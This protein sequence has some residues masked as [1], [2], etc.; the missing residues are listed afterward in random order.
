MSY[1]ERKRFLKLCFTIKSRFY[2]VGSSEIWNLNKSSRIVATH[3]PWPNR[4]IY[5]PFL[6][7]FFNWP[8]VYILIKP[9]SCQHLMRLP[10]QKCH[11]RRLLP[12]L[13]VFVIHP[14]RVHVISSGR[15]AKKFLVPTFACWKITL[16]EVGVIDRLIVNINDLKFTCCVKNSTHENI[17]I[18]V[19]LG[20]IFSHEY[21]HFD[22]E[23]LVRVG[24]GSIYCYRF[25]FKRNPSWIILFRLIWITNRN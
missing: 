25:L 17:I 23:A 9:L 18:S 14:I 5:G 3:R 24:N 13:R 2:R 1:F 11:D 21:P 12:C 6:T 16:A 19:D 10:G 4:A 7:N 22:K 15:R 8:W 20:W